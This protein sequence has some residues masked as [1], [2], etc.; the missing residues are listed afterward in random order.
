M[1]N[2]FFGDIRDY[3]KYGLLR[4]LSGGK[5]ASSAVC[6]MLTP[7][8]VR[9]TKVDY[10][11]RDK[12]WR[13][14]TCWHFDE[15]LFDALQQA[16]CVDEERKVARAKHADI[17]NPE[18]FDFHEEQLKD[19]INK[20]REYFERFLIRSEG[21]DLLFFD[22]DNGLETKGV[23]AGRKG[24]SKFLY[25][26]EL[27]CAFNKQ[28]SILIFQF[29]RQIAP[30][31]VINRRAEQIFSRLDVKEIASFKTNNVIFFLIPQ[32]KHLKELKERSEQVGKV[33]AG[34][35]Q[36]CWHRRTAQVIDAKVTPELTHRRCT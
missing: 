6:W 19:D 4:I 29:Y 17:L 30:E 34:Q 10:L 15:K 33:W 12:T 36:P 14:K 18:V 5:K 26:D 25:L 20:R 35:I 16:V 7:D 23:P 13:Y 31:V 24:S 2:E 1:K 21:K 9:P 11:C 22:P 32:T 8:V 3:R 27:L 28:H